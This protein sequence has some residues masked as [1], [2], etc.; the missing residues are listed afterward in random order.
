MLFDKGTALLGSILGRVGSYLTTKA[1]TLSPPPK[2]SR[3]VKKGDERSLYQTEQGDYFWLNE[4]GHVDR[5]IIDTGVFEP[6]STEVVNTLV[7]PGDHVL[8]IGSNIGYYSVLLSKLVGPEG[9]VVCFE[10]T[11]HFGKVLRKNLQENQLANVE[12]YKFGLSD[13]DQE[14][15]IEIGI[16][17]ATLHSVGKKKLF[18]RENIKL[19]TLD[20]FL[21]NNSLE[22]LDFIKIDVDGHEPFFL[23]GAR[24]TI[25]RFDPA[26]LLE[27]N[28]L[29]YYGSITRF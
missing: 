4:T 18:A 24:E 26:I 28:H 15:E 27:V 19:T 25:D 16:S 20:T 13:K 6:F 21:R 29:N 23:A 1:A 7:K 17:S 10:P 3:L 12:L 8:D 22:R 11:E 9:K 2:R 5:C 14:L